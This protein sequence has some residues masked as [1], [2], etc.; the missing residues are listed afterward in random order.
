[1]RMVKVIKDIVVEGVPYY[2]VI[3]YREYV[4]PEHTMTSTCGMLATEVKYS[5]A[6]LTPKAFFE[7]FSL[8][9]RHPDSVE[10]PKGYTLEV[11]NSKQELYA[12][13]EEFIVM[14]PFIKGILGKYLK[15]VTEEVLEWKGKLA[16]HKTESANTI[17]KLRE[18]LIE[19][20]EWEE[21]RREESL[22]WFREWYKVVN[23][24]RKYKYA[25]FWQRL[26]YLFTGEL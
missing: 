14:S 7:R 4:R 2:D 6:V 8:G 5:Y 23:M 21:Y 1:M 3:H 9:W 18:D 12:V 17:T 10:V 11:D 20:K 13:K 26:K 16:T 15:G 25:T 22:H 19:S 24:D